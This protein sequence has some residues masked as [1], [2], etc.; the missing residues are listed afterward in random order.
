MEFLYSIIAG[1]AGT[2]LMTLFMDAAAR[3]TK[4]NFHVPEILGTMVTMETKP[5]GNVSN[6]M[7]SKVWGYILHYLIGI[8]YTVLYQN[9]L[10]AGIGSSSYGHALVFGTVVGLVAVIFW[11]C[12]F[13]LHPMAPVVRLP[14]YLMFIFWGHPLFAITMNATFKV[15]AQIFGI[16]DSN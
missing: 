15:L 9:L 7:V 2:L 10:Q 8:F 4:Y 11:Y 3:L 5:S 14:L 1:I 12:F 16:I 13:K 6:S